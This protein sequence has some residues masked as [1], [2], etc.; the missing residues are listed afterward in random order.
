MTIIKNV[1]LCHKKSTQRSRKNISLDK[2][3]HR[4]CLK[5]VPIF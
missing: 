1:V 4:R 2:R 3:S 5:N